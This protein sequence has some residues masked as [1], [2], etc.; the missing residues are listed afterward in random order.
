MSKADRK[1]AGYKR[2][3]AYCVCES[4]KMK[5][6]A[7]FLKREHNARP[8]VFDE[9]M[10]AVSS[11]HPVYISVPRD[12]HARYLCSVPRCIIC[13]C[14]QGTVLGRTS[15]RPFLHLPPTSQTELLTLFRRLKEEDT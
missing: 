1:N 14:S 13:L 10:Y 12:V 6:L 4:F 3:T 8:R 7:S 9:A 15:A 5:L 11:L 2:V